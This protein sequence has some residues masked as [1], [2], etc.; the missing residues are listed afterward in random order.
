VIGTAA[1]RAALRERF[2]ARAVR[3]SDTLSGVW[4]DALVLR[5]D[6]GARGGVRPMW[7]FMGYERDLDLPFRLT[8]REL[9]PCVS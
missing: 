8:V 2:N 9:R 6:T 5:L 1:A 7:I 4:V 3:L